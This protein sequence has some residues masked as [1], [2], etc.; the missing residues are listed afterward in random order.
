MR[1]I[2]TSPF[3]N[4]NLLA[5]L[6]YEENF[7]W[8]DE[9][10]IVEFDKTFSYLDKPYNFSLKNDKFI[11]HKLPGNI[12][13]KQP[14]YGL[15]RKFPFIKYKNRKW[16]NEAIHRNFTSSILEFNED[17]ILILSDVDEI[18]DSNYYNELIKEVKKRGIITIKMHYTIYFFNL[19]SS[20]KGAPDWS[21]RVFLMT[22]KYFNNMNFTHDELRKKGERGNLV[23]DIYCFPEYAGFHHSWLGD[24]NFI[25][26]KFKSYSH[27]P[28]EFSN[29]LINSNTQD[30]DK[31]FIKYCIDNRISFLDDMETLSKDKVPLLTSVENLRHRYSNYFI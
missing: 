31:N 4:E 12:Y 9:F 16:I 13:F 15:S 20:N 24:S 21:Y 3:N 17:D 27:E 6:K 2:E 23:N 26:N 25:I 30:F 19:F 18:I 11:H 1:V 7:S 10:N 22:G 28:S 8:I 14:G 5:S 29:R